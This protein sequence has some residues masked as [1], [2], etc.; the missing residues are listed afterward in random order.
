MS[1]VDDRVDLLDFISCSTVAKRAPHLV[2]IGCTSQSINWLT[3]CIS[4][5]PRSPSR[6]GKMFAMAGVKFLMRRVLVKKDDGDIGIVHQVLQVAV[7]PQSDPGSCFQLGVDEFAS[8]SLMDCIS[9]L[10]VSSSS[11]EACSSSLTD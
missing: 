9:S 3:I 2:E 1:H 4:G 8:S 11:F 7:Q 6:S 10:A 5:R